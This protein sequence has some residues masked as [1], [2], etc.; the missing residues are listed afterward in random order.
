M[1][2]T[3]LL[4]RPMEEH[5]LDE[6]SRIEQKAFSQPWSAEAFRDSLGLEHTLF[7]TAEMEGRIVGYCGAYQSLDEAEITNVAVDREF[8]GQRIAEQLLR[9]LFAQGEQRGI[10][11]YTLE[12]RVSNASARRLYARL[13]FAEAGIRKGF[14]EK[15]REDAA[16]LNRS[17]C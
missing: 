2:S 5:D 1:S 4:I 10:Q 9:E 3:G 13:G 11:F 14:Y 15:P 7:L 8:R 6:V 12:V 17:V 16:I